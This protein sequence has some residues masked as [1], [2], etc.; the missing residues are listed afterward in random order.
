MLNVPLALSL[1]NQS[2]AQCAPC[3]YRQKLPFVKTEASFCREVVNYI[4][5]RREWA[6]R[7]SDTWAFV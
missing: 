2:I 7:M 6:N 4:K 5:V 1:I 3:G